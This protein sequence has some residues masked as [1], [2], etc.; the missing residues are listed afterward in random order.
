MSHIITV[1]SVFFCRLAVNI[2]CNII[3]PPLIVCFIIAVVGG[4]KRHF[5]VGQPTVMKRQG[6][7]NCQAQ[8]SFFL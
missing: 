4:T 3:P 5:C 6:D 7:Y 2:H 1:A 8:L